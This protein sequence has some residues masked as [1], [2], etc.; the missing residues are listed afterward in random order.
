MSIVG[1]VSQY[2]TVLKS[3]ADGAYADAQSYISDLHGY[4]VDGVDV[5]PPTVDINA[6]DSITIDETI[7]SQIPSI[8]ND[9]E[10]PDEPT[11]PTTGDFAF[12]TE[13]SYTIPSI[14]ILHDVTFPDFIDGNVTSPSASLPVLDIEEPTFSG[15]DD[16]SLTTDD[17]LATVI[18]GKLTSFVNNGGTMLDPTVEADIWQRDLER[19]QQQ[20]QDSVDRLTDQWSNLGWSLPDGLLASN[21]LALNNE[22]MNKYLDRSREIAIKQAELEQQGVFK[23]MDLG[24]GLSKLLMDN[25][26]D[27]AHRVFEAS[28]VTSDVSLQLFKSRVELYNTSL[29][30]F[31]ADFEAYKARISAE[32]LRVESYKSK[33][34]T[35]QVIASVDETRVKQYLGQVEA[36]GRIVDIYNTNVKSISEKYNAERIKIEGYKIR[37]DAYNSKVDAVTKKF[38]LTVENFKAFVQAYMASADVQNKTNDAELK[39]QIAEVEARLKIWDTQ[40][41]ISSEELALKLETLKAVSQ[42]ASNMVAGSLSA[43]HISAAEQFNA[44][45]GTYKNYNY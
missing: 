22:Y 13:P 18:K 6:S 10:Y 15:I 27:Y 40:Q 45:E 12:P 16:G 21:V 32:L 20:L 35:Q 28:K 7:S 8:P 26:N 31:K 37:V 44:A 19:H 2:L 1:T 34:M 29:E 24:I 39:A 4:V 41:K 36:L 30:A 11:E 43:M 5:T 23:S 14:P 9:S 33:V 38:M 3:Y 17:T 42:T 25:A